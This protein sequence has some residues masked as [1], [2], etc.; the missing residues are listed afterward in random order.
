MIDLNPHYLEDFDPIMLMSRSRPSSLIILAL[1]FLPEA[2]AAYVVD[3]SCRQVIV[4]DT[5]EVVVETEVD[6]VEDTKI[7]LGSLK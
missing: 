4:A 5:M 7:N 1:F 2:Q 6:V 3:D